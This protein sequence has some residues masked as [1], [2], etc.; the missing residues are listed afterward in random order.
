MK[1][2]AAL[3]FF[4]SFSSIVFSQQIS[5]AG[6]WTVTLDSG[7]RNT[8]T[9]QLPGTLDDAG[10]GQPVAVNSSSTIGTFAHLQRKV[11]YVGKALYTKRFTIPAAWKQSQITLTL[12][13]VLWQSSIS[14][15]GKVLPVD[16]QSLSTSHAYD[17]TDYV[18]P[19]KEQELKIT[20]DN[21]NKYPGI[22]IYATQYPSVES[23]EMTHAY[24]NHTQIKWNGIIGDIT[25]SR[26][27]LT[28]LQHVEVTTIDQKNIQVKWRLQNKSAKQV[29]V[30]SFI[31][32]P[33]TNRRWPE[34]ITRRL[35]QTDT[36]AAVFSIPRTAVFWNEFSP[37]LYQLVTMVHSDAGSDTVRTS[38]GIRQL[39]TKEGDLYLNDSRLFIRSNLEC[40]IFPLTGYP[41]M[42]ITEWEQLFRKAKSYGL[43]SF[44]FHSWCPPQAAFTA[45]DK[46]GFYLQVELPHW[47]LKVGSDMA[48]FEFLRNEAKRILSAYG[49]HPSFMFFSMGNELEGDFAKLNALVAE[50]KQIDARHLYSTT[51]FTFQKEMYIYPLN[52]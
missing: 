32:D 18:K 8:Y 6:K 51:T 23:A 9:I 3:I 25:V 12:G 20:V 49:N 7:S 44:R 42:K 14:I 13:R 35:L 24:T 26:K 46:V 39:M 17:I 31:V 41:P 4:I 28:N 48:A 19:G 52:I 30:E 40:I 15:N 11:Q 2:A 45:A 36:T 22:N 38:F 37:K 34:R 5:L 47:N 43:N 27:S 29:R 16:E 10:I 21:G 1:K 33:A 50:L